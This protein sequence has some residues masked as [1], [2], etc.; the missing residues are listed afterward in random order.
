MTLSVAYQC[1]QHEHVRRGVPGSGPRKPYLRSRK[2]QFRCQRAEVPQWR[3]RV[4][5]SSLGHPERRTLLGIPSVPGEIRQQ[6]H[7]KAKAGTTM[8]TRCA[9]EYQQRGFEL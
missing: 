6:S 2:C 3:T 9:L 4:P 8:L 7:H 1:R 5:H